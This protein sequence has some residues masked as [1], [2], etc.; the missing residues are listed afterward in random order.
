M[1]I[2]ISI[3]KRIRRRVQVA[4]NVAVYVRYVLN[5][6][7]PH[8]GKRRQLFANSHKEAIARRD[9]LVAVLASNRY[10][11]TDNHLTVEQAVEHWLENRRPEV[12]GST[13][14]TYR[15]VARPYIIGPLLIGTPAER[16]AYTESGSKPEVKTMRRGGSW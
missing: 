11:D 12:K 16:K 15:Q 13:W 9:A 3:T 4:G 6:R 10:S 5:L 2:T 14:K 1:T 7:D 8:T